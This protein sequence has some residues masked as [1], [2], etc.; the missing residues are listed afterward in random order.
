MEENAESIALIRGDA[1]ELGSVLQNY[2]RVVTAWIRQIHRNG[3]VATVQS[4]NG[5]LTPLFPLVLVAPKYL[6]GALTLGAVMQL[7]SAFMLVQVAFN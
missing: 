5:A 7:A 2:R 3:V 6:S 1:D 4:A